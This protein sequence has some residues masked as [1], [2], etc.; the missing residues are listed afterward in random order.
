RRRRSEPS[1][2]GRVVAACNR[3]DRGCEP[4]RQWDQGNRRDALRP[5]VLDTPLGGTQA[6]SAGDRRTWT[7]IAHRFYPHKSRLAIHD[8][9]VSATLAKTTAQPEEIG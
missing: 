8:A 4:Y 2:E 9:A 3:D 1:D 7:Q 6:A 5:P